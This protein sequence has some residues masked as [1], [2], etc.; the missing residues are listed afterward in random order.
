MFNVFISVILLCLLT[1]GWTKQAIQRHEFSFYK[2]EICFCYYIGHFTDKVFS[3]LMSN[4]MKIVV[5][6]SPT[7]ILILRNNNNKNVEEKITNFVTDF[8]L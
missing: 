8:M 2:L 4:M 7:L 5:G 6:F 1:V 3:E